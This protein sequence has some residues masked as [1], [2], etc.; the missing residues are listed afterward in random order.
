MIVI[1]GAPVILRLWLGCLPVASG[2]MDQ[3]RTI[4]FYVDI[5][6]EPYN[7]LS[8]TQPQDGMSPLL[9]SAKEGYANTVQLLLNAGADA[10]MVSKVRCAGLY[11]QTA[12]QRKTT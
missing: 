3:G 12:V 10:H 11:T 1:S 9:M 5:V 8:P 7:R 4:I 2:K 6:D